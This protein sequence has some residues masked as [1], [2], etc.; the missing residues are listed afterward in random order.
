MSKK[1]DGDIESQ[2]SKME[3]AIGGDQSDENIAALRQALDRD[4][5]SIQKHL[6]EESRKTREYQVDEDGIEYYVEDGRK[7]HVFNFDEWWLK[8]YDGGS[9]LI[10]LP[11]FDIFNTK[12]AHV[13]SVV[14]SL[15]SAY[16]VRP[17]ADEECDDCFTED[18]I[19]AHIERFPQGQFAAQRISG[20]SAGNC[21]GMATTM[22]ASRPPTAPI[23]PWREA[24]GDMTLSAH[25]PDGDW[26]Y[27]VEMA[28]HSM[29]QRHGIG[30]GLYEARFD[31]ARRLNLRGFYAVG[32]LMGYERH[33]DDMDVIEYGEKV[34]AGE[35]NDPTVTMQ[36]N[37]GFRAVRV[38]TGYCDEPAAG[39]AGALIVWDNP[40]YEE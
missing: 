25:E 32:M 24:I 23:L 33:A 3:A 27:G 40:D 12:P 35:I 37:R 36:M 17:Y 21:V 6:L 30:T 39:D 22:R 14:I 9:A 20:P 8:D 19:L 34:I 29:Y 18:D 5:P 1:S 28:V 26:L 2:I 7:I 15:W 4:W 16:G 13:S 38:V 11:G 10:R 31:L